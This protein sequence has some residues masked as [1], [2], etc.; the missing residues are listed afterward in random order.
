MTDA[1]EVI[2]LEAGAGDRRYLR[3]LWNFR[4]LFL[5]LAKRDIALRYKQAV[6]GVAWA[7]IRPLTTTVVFAFAFGQVARLPSQGVPYHL[8]VLAGALPWQLFASALSEGGSS[9]VSNANIVAK[10]YFPRLIVPAA[11]MLVGLVDLAVSLS[12]LFAMM[13]W[14]QVALTA[15]LLLVPLFIALT[16]LV[17]LG[18]SLWISALNVRYRDMR[19][20][21]PFIVQVG[22]FVSPVGYGSGSVPASVQ[23]IYRYN[24]MVAPIDGLRWCLF[25]AAPAHFEQGL[26]VSLA[27]GLLLL[28][29]GYFYFKK[30]E[31]TFADVI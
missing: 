22:L 1:D 21:V 18:A 13:L 23:W 19:H 12:I 11:S 15:K 4:E 31:T 29:S 28:V 5:V 30:T 14:Y 24:P 27:A 7:L 26:V 16:V 8:F 9:I 3:E 25:G 10:T 17:S 20:V 6:F 2:V